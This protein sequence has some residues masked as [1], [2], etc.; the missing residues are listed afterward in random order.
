MTGSSSNNNN[1]TPRITNSGWIHLRM[2]NGGSN[3]SSNSSNNDSS[4]A[5]P[6]SSSNSNRRDPY[7]GIGTPLA[8]GSSS[9]SSFPFNLTTL[10]ICIGAAVGL[11]VIVGTSTSGMCQNRKCH[12]PDEPSSSQ[13]YL[14]LHRI[15]GRHH[16]IF[17]EGATFGP[18]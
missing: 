9:T 13:F 18:P 8:A 12:S 4:M 2:P 7:R 6:S 16:D 11:F 3:S 1:T 5:H 17:R 10:A 14:H 15:R